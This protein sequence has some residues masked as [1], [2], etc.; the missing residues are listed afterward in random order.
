MLW[1]DDSM[2]IADTFFFSSSILSS[3]S[4]F[5]S[6]QEEILLRKA[7]RRILSNFIIQI[8]NDEI[9]E[10][11][12]KKKKYFLSQCLILAIDSVKSDFC[13]SR[14]SSLKS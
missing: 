12:E 6:Y 11:D 10:E 14:H 3:L 9:Q 13:P 7:D 5:K 1:K 4:L 2:C 8:G